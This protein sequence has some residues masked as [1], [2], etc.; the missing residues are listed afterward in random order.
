MGKSHLLTRIS[1]VTIKQGKRVV[2]VDLQLIDSAIRRVPALFF[3]QLCARISEE[4]N[5]EIRVDEH[6]NPL[7]G[8]VNCC[9]RYIEKYVLPKVAGPVT[10]IVD[11]TRQYSSIRGW[12]RLRLDASV[13]AYFV[14]R[15]WG[16]LDL[17]LAAR[18][19]P[20]MWLERPDNP[21]SMW[22]LR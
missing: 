5:Q 20:Y 3:Q 13:M 11:E 4:L 9:T 22:A 8:N 2:V 19:E 17:V 10:L 12:Q 16:E 15:V 7:L 21:R 1:E 6:W 18:T 14:Q